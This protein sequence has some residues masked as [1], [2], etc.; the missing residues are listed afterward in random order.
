MVFKGNNSDI[1][2]RVMRGRSWWI[3]SPVSDPAF[4]FLWKPFSLGINFDSISTGINQQM[5][6]H[7]ENHKEITRKSNLF[8]NLQDFA[9]VVYFLI[10]E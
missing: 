9:E 10:I 8:I 2:K 3:E 1:I 4:N 7:L 6:N 5:V